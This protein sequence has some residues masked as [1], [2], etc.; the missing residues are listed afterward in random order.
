MHNDS[1]CE[2]NKAECNGFI[3][4]ETCTASVF[5]V[6]L[7]LNVKTIIDVSEMKRHTDLNTS[8]RLRQLAPTPTSLFT[9]QLCPQLLQ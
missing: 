6:S 2:N 7:V 5:P 4:V 1:T 8:L 9:L 3:A